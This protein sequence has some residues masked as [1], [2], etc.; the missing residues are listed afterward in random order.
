MNGLN[1]FFDN[2][3]QDIWESVVNYLDRSDIAR[4]NAVAK[5]SHSALHVLCPYPIAFA[6]V[7]TG[8]KRLFQLPKQYQTDFSFI[9]RVLCDKFLVD[10]DVRAYRDHIAQ[11][12]EKKLISKRTYEQLKDGMTRS[13]IISFFVHNPYIEVDQK[14]P[15]IDKIRSFIST[16]LRLKIP[17]DSMPEIQYSEVFIYNLHTKFENEKNKLGKQCM[18]EYLENCVKTFI[19]FVESAGLKWKNMQNYQLRCKLRRVDDRMQKLLSEFES[20]R[21]NQN[22]KKRNISELKLEDNQIEKK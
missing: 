7:M 6:L 19:T 5:V 10:Q 2:V 8:Q 9:T 17:T 11:Q 13:L 18:N 12:L 3:S 1:I 22:V 20:D 15:T 21:L 4:L 16:F 14:N